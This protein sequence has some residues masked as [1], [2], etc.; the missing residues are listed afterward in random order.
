[1]RLSS[2]ALCIA[3]AV[4]APLA[5]TAQSSPLTT[6]TMIVSGSAA[7]E[8]TTDQG[9]SVRATTINL[10][11]SVQWFITSQLALGGSVLLGYASSGDTHSST[12]ELAHP[13][14]SS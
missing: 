14:G 11:P 2:N 5:V 12:S 10:A 1:M 3:L 6:G 4:L 8:R 9:S 13:L 7:L